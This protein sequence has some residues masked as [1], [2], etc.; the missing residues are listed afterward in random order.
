MS[1][2]VCRAF[3]TS[4]ARGIKFYASDFGL[5]VGGTFY[6]QLEPSIMRMTAITALLCGLTATLCWGILLGKQP[7]I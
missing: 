3:F 4:Q 5:V 1:V 2:S 6:C 7:T